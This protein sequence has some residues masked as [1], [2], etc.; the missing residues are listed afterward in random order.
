MGGIKAEPC[1]LA[2]MGTRDSAGMAYETCQIL[3]MVQAWKIAVRGTNN[4]NIHVHV[5]RIRHTVTAT[6]KIFA[7][8]R[9]T[10]LW[11][12]TVMFRTV[13]TPEDML[14]SWCWPTLGQTALTASCTVWPLPV[15]P[16]CWGPRSERGPAPQLQTGNRWFVIS[17][18]EVR[19]Q[20]YD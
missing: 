8:Y 1:A 14:G 19:T 9:H 12:N 11:V 5:D 6:K 15:R 17:S 7:C 3:P 20:A 10:R 4:N 18:P 13:W 16:R 2:M